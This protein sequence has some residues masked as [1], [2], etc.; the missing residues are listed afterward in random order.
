M[1][2]A[3]PSIPM[4]TWLAALRGRAGVLPIGALDAGLAVALAAAQ[5]L[6][7]RGY[8]AAATAGRPGVLGLGVAVALV[9]TLPLVARRRAPFAVF[10]TVAAAT[11]AHAML[12][13]L[14][15]GVLAGP[16]LGSFVALYSV[17]AHDTQARSWIAAAVGVGWIGVLYVVTEGADFL[18]F[19]SAVLVACWVSGR[20]VRTRALYVAELE[21]DREARAR[22]AVAHERARI[23]R[24]LHDV[25]A[26]AVSVIHVQA[27]A[28]RGALHTDVPAADAALEAVE[29]TAGQAL[30]EMRLLLGALHDDAAAPPRSPQ[31]GV[32]DLAALVDQYRQAGLPVRIDQAADPLPLPAAVGVAAYRIVQ[33]SLTNVL[34][35]AHPSEV[36]VR[37]G[38]D[39]AGLHVE[40]VNDGAGHA[41]RPTGS[42]GGLGLAGM[43][44]RVGLLGGHLIAGPAPAGGFRVLAT[45]PVEQRRPVAREGA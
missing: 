5:V 30:G 42:E 45:L 43:R 39:D 16:V 15:Q 9:T 33:E 37:V 25:I 28:A 13:V 10:A 2:G 29:R 12:P 31:P 40:V 44:E 6:I 34:K 32:T 7:L 8:W 3:L 19:F 24:E 20:L 17:A 21:R 1:A 4:T 27:R 26:H 23:A 35:H 14:T 11:F 36:V 38:H 22:L 41:S 18:P